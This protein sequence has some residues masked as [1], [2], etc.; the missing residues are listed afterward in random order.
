MATL[1]LLKEIRLKTSITLEKGRVKSDGWISF[2]L[3][4]KSAL[5]NTQL[6]IV[7]YGNG[8]FAR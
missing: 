4:S 7:E 8:A 6:L 2:S 5:Q 3:L 1:V